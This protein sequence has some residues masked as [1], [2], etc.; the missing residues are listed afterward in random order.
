MKNGLSN[1]E[2]QLLLAEKE[3]HIQTLEMIIARNQ[4][5]IQHSI[6]LCQQRPPARLVAMR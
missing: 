2:M 5:I 1:S 3:R 4:D 6:G